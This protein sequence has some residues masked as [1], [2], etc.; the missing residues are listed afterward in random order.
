VPLEKLKS[1]KSSFR[2]SAHRAEMA[3][4]L[5]VLIAR[6]KAEILPALRHL[7]RGAKSK[8]IEPH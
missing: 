8:R 6:G 1:L 2:L 5:G 3:A 7:R 4:T